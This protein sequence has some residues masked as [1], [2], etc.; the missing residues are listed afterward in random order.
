ME[1]AK[2]SWVAAKAAA[3][4]AGFKFIYERA[5]SPGESDFT[6][7]V[8][9]MKSQGVKLVYILSEDVSTLAKFDNAVRSQQ[10]NPILIEPVA[11]GLV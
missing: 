3:E 6:A 7:D 4:H 11:F 2:E 9:S 5:T 8:V 10:W 1:S